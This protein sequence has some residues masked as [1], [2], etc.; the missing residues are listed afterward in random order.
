MKYNN[1]KDDADGT[2][3]ALTD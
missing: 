1:N 3:I 2:I